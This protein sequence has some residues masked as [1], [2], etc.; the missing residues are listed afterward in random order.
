LVFKQ[1]DYPGLA[2]PFIL[3][4]M[5]LIP[6]A[7]LYF[8]QISSAYAGDSPV[9]AAFLIVRRVPRGF[10]LRILVSSIHHYFKQEVQATKAAR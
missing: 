5:R 6:N 4:K 10:Y 7:I 3:F 1:F 8:N 2:R 9:L